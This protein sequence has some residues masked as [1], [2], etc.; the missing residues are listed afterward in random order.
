MRC[1]LSVL[2]GASLSGYGGLLAVEDS[3][4]E[5]LDLLKGLSKSAGCGV[6]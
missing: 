4:E 3:I 5:E 2:G 1:I 6:T